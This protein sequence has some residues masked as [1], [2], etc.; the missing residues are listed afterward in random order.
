MPAV[1]PPSTSPEASKGQPTR[2]FNRH[3]DSDSELTEPE[4]GNTYFYAPSPDE[5]AEL[6]QDAL[7][8]KAAYE[9]Y[10]LSPSPR[11][12][13]PADIGTKLEESLL[14]SWAGSEPSAGRVRLIRDLLATLTAGLNRW[15]P[16]RDLRVDPFGSVAWGGST[17]SNGDLDLVIIVRCCYVWSGPDCSPSQDKRL[18]EGC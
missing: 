4:S 3:S 9:L 15:E 8:D 11:L 2:L 16:Q 10:L 6:S 1:V 17:G 12:S 5:M 7:A 13:L 18:P 14:R